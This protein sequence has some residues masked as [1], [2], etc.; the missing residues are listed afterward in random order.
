MDYR[1]SPISGLWAPTKTQ[2]VH[3][4]PNTVENY[5][6]SNL[7][8]SKSRAYLIISKDCTLNE[9]LIYQI[10]TL[11]RGHIAGVFSHVEKY[12]TMNEIPNMIKGMMQT[13]NLDT[14]ISLGDDVVIDSSKILSSAFQE[15]SG[16]FLHHIAIPAT[17]DAAE[18]TSF[19]RYILHNGLKNHFEEPRLA[20]RV[21]LYDPMIGARTPVD[22]YLATGIRA[23]DHAIEVI[24]SLISSQLPARL[25]ALRAVRELIVLLPTYRTCSN[26]VKIMDLITRL[27]LCSFESLGLLGMTGQYNLGLSHRIC[28]A[29]STVCSVPHAFISCMILPGVV[30]LQSRF[31]EAAAQIAT[32]L[33]IISSRETSGDNEKDCM[34][35]A[36]YIQGLLDKLD[37]RFRLS[38]FG[39]TESQVLLAVK[40]AMEGVSEELYD[41]VYHL[42]M[43]VL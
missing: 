28:Y 3:F 10:E 39:V 31:P 23:L 5:L 42:L 24:Y 19:T 32:I 9:P 2:R 8:S 18:C 22:I 33:P 11:L 16:K 29:M 12:I 13:P 27:Q 20:P 26:P 21:I 30:T 35:V 40:L 15:R 38:N 14:I 25:L 36:Y 6:V 34:W 37:L 1:R 7:P 41:G 4:G 17:L 43:D